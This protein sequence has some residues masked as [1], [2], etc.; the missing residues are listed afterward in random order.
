MEGR[1]D[2][3]EECRDKLLPTFQTSCCFWMPAQVL[4]FR[5]PTRSNVAFGCLH[6]AQV[7]LNAHIPPLRSP[8][9]LIDASWSALQCES[10]SPQ[11]LNF[12]FVPQQFRVIYIATCR[13]DKLFLSLF[14]WFS[15]TSFSRGK[16]ETWCKPAHFLFPFFSLISDEMSTS[17]CFGWTFCASSR[18]VQTRRKSSLSPSNG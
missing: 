4:F 14:S 3:L 17:V 16:D 10:F 5:V 8:D 1:E 15:M 6:T 18:G 9:C 2:L 7:F 12:A 11:A 13:Y